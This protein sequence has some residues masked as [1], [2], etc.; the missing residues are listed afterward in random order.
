MMKKLLF[1]LPIVLSFMNVDVARAN[2]EYGGEYVGDGLFSE[3]G[4]RFVIS[5][6]GGASFSMGKIKNDIGELSPAYYYDPVT[7]IVIS[8]GFLDMTCGTG[9][10]GYEFGG[11]G[12]IGELKAKK[13]YNELAFTAGASVGWVIPNNTNWRLEIG[14]DR[15]T[16]TNYN[17]APLFDGDIE[18]YGGV[19]DGLIVNVQS[20]SVHSTVS[21]DIISAMAFYDFFDGNNRKSDG[22]IPY[23]GFGVGYANSETE[24]QLTD[25]YGDLTLQAD[26]QSYGERET[27]LALD[28]Y[29]SKTSS[30]NIAGVLA[31]GAS[32][33]L[34]DAMYLD[35][36]VRFMYVPE[37]KWALANEDD[38]RHRDWF[39]AKNVFFTNVLVGLRFEF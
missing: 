1:V 3:D 26:L 2:W 27:G 15:I 36:G 25:S 21:T 11:Y 18:L 13:N 12:N 32:Y 31:L 9:C 23:I 33:G 28:F 35:F 8:D 38:T 10:S 17:A 6:R 5:L 16:K 37:I 29:K 7:G 19:L 14:W 39:S 34:S 24:L 4:S 30:S 22:I 20:G